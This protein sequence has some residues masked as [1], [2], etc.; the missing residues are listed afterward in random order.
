M[1]HGTTDFPQRPFLRVATLVSHPL[2][3]RVRTAVIPPGCL[4]TAR[5]VRDLQVRAA[6]TLGDVAVLEPGIDPR[7]EAVV[8]G[9]W[10]RWVPLVL[11]APLV[12]R[13]MHAAIALARAVDGSVV[14][15]GYDDDPVRFRT[16]LE[17]VRGSPFGRVL[18]ER[19]AEQLLRL[20]NRM[21]GAVTAVCVSA[22]AQES[23]ARL[24]AAGGVDQSTLA[25][26]FAKAGLCKPLRLVTATRMVRAYP[27]L[28]DPHI[29]GAQV[30]RAVGV[31][32]AAALDRQLRTLVGARL[33]ELRAEV[34]DADQFI[35]R[36]MHAVVRDT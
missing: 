36:V 29:S 34:I 21:R 33:R 3:V 26:Q 32:S 4:L 35:E 17:S 22:T 20:P 6:H 15:A 25:R 11:Y 8:T 5:D 19:L 7:T 28:V 10:S 1:R 9:Q 14:I 23:V 2:E 30:A 27:L 13:E 18:A 12:V 16:G 24:A 31:A